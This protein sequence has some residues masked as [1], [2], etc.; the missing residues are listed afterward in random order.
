[1]SSEMSIELEAGVLTIRFNRPEKKNALTLAMY[2]AA[3]DAIKRAEQDPAIK[4]IVF[5][6]T[7]D[8]FSSGNDI[9]DFLSVPPGADDS[10]V[11]K[12]LLT[13]SATDMPILAAVNGSAVGIG[14]T[15]LMHCE[16]VYSVD[17]ARF[18][19]PFITL[20]VVPEAGSSLLMP[21][22]LGYQRAA[23]MLVF[24]ESITAQEAQVCG[25]VS[26]LCTADSLMSEVMADAKRIAG[27]PKKAMQNA[28]RLLRRAEEPLDDRIKHEM[29]EFGVALRSPEAKEAM[30]AF[31]EKRPADFSKLEA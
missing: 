18:S 2:T 6:G 10:P 28:K 7:G 31:M 19:T 26:E 27:L 15:M 1:M 12:F 25:L 8:I 5:T 4:V 3:D 24:G 22:F 23:R 17:S 13:L 9:G 20:A 29:Q 14:T 21:K 11:A 30:L 16:K